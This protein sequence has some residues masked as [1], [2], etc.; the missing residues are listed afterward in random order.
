MPAARFPAGNPQDKA[1]LR[2]LSAEERAK[3]QAAAKAARAA[4]PAV[5]QPHP[6]DVPYLKAIL[7]ERGIRRIPAAEP[8][9]PA[10]LM[11]LARRAKVNIRDATGLSAADLIARNPDRALWWLLATAM[12]VA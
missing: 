1:H 5:R 12:E 8:A 4:W 6:D 11:R 9:T 2:P 3:G 7:A 10:R